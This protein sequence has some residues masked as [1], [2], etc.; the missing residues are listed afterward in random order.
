MLF[1]LEVLQADY[2]DCLLLHFGKKTTPKIIV[3]DGGP[4]GIYDRSLRPRLLEIKQKL[5]PESALPL[6]MIMVSHLDDDHVNGILALIDEVI[7]KKD[8]REK[9][10]LGLKNLWVNTFDDIIGNLQIPSLTS[11]P[12]SASPADINSLPILANAERSINAMIASTG[13]GRQIRDNAAKLS[14]ILNK[15]FK[16]LKKGT[17][18]LVRSD[19]K[20]TVVPWEE[21]KITVL[22]PNEERLKKL[23]EQWDRDLKKALEKGDQSVIIASLADTDTS[24]FNLSSIVCLMEFEGKKILLTGDARS[25]DVLTGLSE[26]GLLDSKGKIHVDVLKLPHHGSIRNASEAF[27]ES[28]T[29]DHYIIS[30]NG[31]FDNPDKAL[32]DMMADT[33]KRGTLHLTNHEGQKELKAKVASFTKDLKVK[34]NKLKVSFRPEKGSIVI[35]LL[36]KISF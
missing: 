17:A 5:S 33:V 24:P 12:A 18:N 35:D 7:Q 14:L 32:L 21:I 16:A 20:N 4:P 23:Q 19:G 8:D 11:M 13:Q 2:G 3:I 28:I 22:H 34:G 31:K 27:F 26:N 10:L 36:E 25:K 1:T 9:P 15:P 6:S 29:A 30:A